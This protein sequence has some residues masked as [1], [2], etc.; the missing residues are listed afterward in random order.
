MKPTESL[1]L[2]HAHSPRYFLTSTAGAE[3]AEVGGGEVGG[4]RLV[5]VVGRVC[6]FKLVR[7]R[8]SGDMSKYLK[9]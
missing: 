3:K 7:E 2:A 8:F 9:R 5:L 4:G 1:T 6:R